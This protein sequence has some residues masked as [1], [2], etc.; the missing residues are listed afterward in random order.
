MRGPGF[1][2]GH[3]CGL[4]GSYVPFATTRAARIA[5]GDPRPSLEERYGNHDGYV[6]AV[7]AAADEL[8]RARL[9]LPEDAE[10]YVREAET[11]DVLRLGDR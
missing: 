8:V 6:S 3:T 7:R 5:E 4:S 1:R 10:R 2:E 11:S 9:L